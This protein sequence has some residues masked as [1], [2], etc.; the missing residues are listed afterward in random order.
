MDG[1]DPEI[2]NVNVTDKVKIFKDN[3]IVE[4]LRRDNARRVHKTEKK[5][6]KELEMLP[7]NG[8]IHCAQQ[9]IKMNDCAQF[10]G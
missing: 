4:H 10:Y 8:L 2:R 1:D 5:E 9:L 6:R 3:L 7:R